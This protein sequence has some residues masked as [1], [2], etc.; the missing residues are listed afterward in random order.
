MPR[1]IIKEIA[2]MIVLLTVVGSFGWFIWWA[3]QNED[4]DERQA[5][6]DHYIDSSP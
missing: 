1:T 6:Y 3:H 5:S 4:R 2:G